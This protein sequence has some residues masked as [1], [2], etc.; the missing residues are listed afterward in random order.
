MLS[1][2]GVDQLVVPLSGRVLPHS[3]LVARAL[4]NRGRRRCA[5]RASIG[6]PRRDP[7]AESGRDPRLRQQ[8]RDVPGDGA[9]PPAGEGLWLEQ[10]IL[11]YLSRYARPE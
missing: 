1:A 3:D 8:R 10:M 5:H 2:D 4:E 6:D 11:A 9:G 7:A